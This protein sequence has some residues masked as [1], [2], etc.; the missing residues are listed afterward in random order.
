MDFLEKMGRS[1][2]TGPVGNSNRIEIPGAREP[3]FEPSSGSHG[4]YA[5]GQVH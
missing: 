3:E 2:H 4:L 5:L 1:V